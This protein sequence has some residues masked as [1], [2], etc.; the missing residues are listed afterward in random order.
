[1]IRAHCA[2]MRTEHP[3]QVIA[4]FLPLSHVQPQLVPVLQIL[5]NGCYSLKNNRHPNSWEVHV[6][7]IS[8]MQ[9]E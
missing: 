2:K 3:R 1:M 7:K 6:S 4:E 8:V 9:D 5:T